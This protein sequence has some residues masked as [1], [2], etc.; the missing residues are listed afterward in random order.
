MVLFLILRKDPNIFIS[1]ISTLLSPYIDQSTMYV[2]N[3]AQIWTDLHNRFSKS[4]HF[5]L[6]DLV[7]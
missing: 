5:L 3:V 6:F 4:D 2:D 1:W 7:E